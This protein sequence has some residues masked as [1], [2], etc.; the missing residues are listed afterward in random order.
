MKTFLLLL[1]SASAVLSETIQWNANPVTD[2]VDYY[3]VTVSTNGTAIGVFTV[4]SPQTNMV[5]SFANG[6]TYK[7]AVVAIDID[8]LPSQ[9][10][11]IEYIKNVTPPPIPVPPQINMV[12]KNKP[13]YDAATETWRNLQVFWSVPPQ[14]LSAYGATEYTLR[15]VS[16]TGTNLFK[17]ASQ[18]YTFGTLQ[19]RDYTFDVY[20]VG[21]SGTSPLGNRLIMSSSRPRNPMFVIVT[22]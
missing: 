4:T 19:V 13:S 14:P 15:V 2:E 18:A 9:P 1:L 8:N 20:V 21:S 22:P 3:K 11:T 16:S 6:Y 10:T 5:Y 7:I 12:G 17:T